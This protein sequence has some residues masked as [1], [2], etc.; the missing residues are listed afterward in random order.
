[1]I[2]PQ[3]ILRPYHNIA[4][5][6]PVEKKKKIILERQP[7][8]S[9]FP[10]GTPEDT[11]TV[12]VWFFSQYPRFFTL[13]ACSIFRTH[14]RALSLTQDI[15]RQTWQKSFNTAPCSILPRCL[16]SSLCLYRL[17]CRH[18]TTVVLYIMLLRT[19][20]FF[21]LRCTTNAVNPASLALVCLNFSHPY[22]GHTQSHNP[23]QIS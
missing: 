15:Y 22:A 16:R 6:I 19:I 3:S 17:L 11:N 23:Q 20:V 18:S 12:L 1:M 10:H 5:F 14:I 2:I 7:V 4:S 13:C 21:D 9:L 8:Q